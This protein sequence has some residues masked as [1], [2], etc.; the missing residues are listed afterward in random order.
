[1]QTIRITLV[2]FFGLSVSAYGQRGK[3]H[4]DLKNDTFKAIQVD[5]FQLECIDLT[6]ESSG[7]RLIIDEKGDV[8]GSF[9]GLGS[10][11]GYGYLVKQLVRID[12]KGIVASKLPKYLWL[13]NG[14]LLLYGNHPQSHRGGGISIDIININSGQSTGLIDCGSAVSSAPVADKDGNVWIATIHQE[15]DKHMS[16]LKVSS[17]NEISVEGR[18]P[19]LWAVGLELSPDGQKVLCHGT[20]TGM[21]Q[22]EYYL[23]HA[24]KRS[25][26]QRI[27]GLLKY[28]SWITNSG[29]FTTNGYAWR[30]INP[31][32]TSDE[33]ELKWFN[34]PIDFV[35][36]I[37][38]L[39]D[40]GIVLLGSQKLSLAENELKKG[41][42]QS[43]VLFIDP[44][45]G[46]E[47]EHTVECHS[48]EP[49][50]RYNQGFQS[51]NLPWFCMD[52]TLIKLLK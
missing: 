36:A 51:N 12:D 17:T 16:L 44:K 32:D 4:I 2:L 40:S 10:D 25:E 31:Q 29:L 47:S 18:L 7:S 11:N 26:P 3:D 23:F 48:I 38:F 33:V 15:G 41:K 52:E 43:K 42:R 21:F 14:R 39:Q 22:P 6:N 46:S 37:A 13:P 35:N 9:E 8:I 50:F 1:M 5:A 34:S 28:N 45:S 27:T 24:N 19:I 30:I 49:A 20:Q